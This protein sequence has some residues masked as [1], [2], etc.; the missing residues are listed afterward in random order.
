MRY[1]YTY[2]E[3]MTSTLQKILC[4]CFSKKNWYK[5]RAKR[6]Q[7]HELAMDSLTKET[8]FFN[9]LKLLRTTEFMS[10]LYLKEYQRGMIPYFKKYQLTEL[11]GDRSK[12]VFDTHNL[13]STAM[14][15]IDG[16]EE[17]REEQRMT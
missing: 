8:D 4:C 15:L 11:E 2:F 16:D 6:L 17:E 10:K 12:H 1:D 14:H 13:G 5:R 3:F 7:R 9:F